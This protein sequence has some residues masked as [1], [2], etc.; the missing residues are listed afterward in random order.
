MQMKERLAQALKQEIKNKPLTRVTVSDLVRICDINRNTFYYHF[1]DIYALLEWSVQREMEGLVCAVDPVNNTE[2]A[3]RYILA[4]LKKNKGL[5]DSTYSSLGYDLLQQYVFGEVEKI[6]KGIVEKTVQRDGAM[7][8]DE[9]TGFLA[10]FYTQAI[11]G[12]LI[13]WVRGSG[14]SGKKRCWTICC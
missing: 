7:L 2:E 9:F 14:A 10:V 13:A 3:I 5:L 6:V 8:D 4:Y 1:Q 12:M 11:S